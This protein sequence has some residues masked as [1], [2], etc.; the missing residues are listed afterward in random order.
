MT[1]LELP[2][3]GTPALN[4][5]APNYYFG[6][7][8]PE[9]CIKMKKKNWTRGRD[10]FLA[11]LYIR[12]MFKVLQRSV[13]FI[14]A[15][16]PGLKDIVNQKD[17]NNFHWLIQGGLGDMHTFQIS[18]ISYFFGGGRKCSNIRLVSLPLK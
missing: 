6:P 16:A 17:M 8:Y 13:V 2:R 14:L 12:S 18:F 3:L 10:T 1:D 7:F 5:A 15:G 4:V 11:H 9:N